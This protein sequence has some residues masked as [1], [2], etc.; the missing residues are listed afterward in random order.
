MILWGISMNTI[1]DVKHHISDNNQQI[2]QKDKFWRRAMGFTLVEL[3]VTIAVM[4]IIATMAAPSFSQLIHERKLDGD[5]RD[6]ALVLS[7]MRGQ[8]A[9]LRKDITLKLQSGTSTATTYFWLPKSNGVVFRTDENDLDTSD[10]IF[11]P[12]GVPMQRTKQIDNPACV[13]GSNPN[14]CATD[15]ANNKYKIDQVLPL[16]FK[17]CDPSI[18]Q[19]RTINISIN[20]TIQQIEKGVC[21]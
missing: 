14:P 13:S 10:V 16:K 7:D 3:M 11:S 20:G 4:A 18:K 19:S 12:V 17:L 21:S 6:L 8:A 15:P 5:A 9:T 2:S 1:I